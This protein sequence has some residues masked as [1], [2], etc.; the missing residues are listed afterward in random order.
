M[1]SVFN[2]HAKKIHRLLLGL[3]CIIFW[4]SCFK[5]RTSDKEVIKKFL[6]K[7]R[8]VRIGNYTYDSSKN[9]H[10][11]ESGLTTSPTIFFV[12]G[13]PGSSNNF[14]K[15]LEDSTLA[16]TYRMIA[17]DRPGFGYSNFGKAENLEKQV[18]I[19]N[20]F[21]QHKNNGKPVIL[22]GHSLGGPIVVGMAAKDSNLTD[23]LLLLAAS[24]SPEHEPAE[25]WRKPLAMPVLRW[26]VPG[27][28]R[29]S[30][31][32]MID[33]KNYVQQMPFLLQQISAPTYLIH[34]T[35][36]MFVPY[37]NVAFAEKHLT[38][39]KQINVITLENENHFI[40]W[41]KFEDL[42][43]LLLYI[44]PQLKKD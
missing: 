38:R 32:E 28:M 23:M 6:V 19:F 11:I 7:N 3:V 16:S 37:E 20:A 15:F 8:E 24:V 4:Q 33:F 31:D 17:I 21:L 22:A 12:H 26:L 42:R 27:A 1:L 5:F 35:K 40:P 30:N 13:T 9:M 39:A 44:Y 25:S 10:Y 14:L 18:E 34:G 29:P 36:D 2:R 43:L 41:T